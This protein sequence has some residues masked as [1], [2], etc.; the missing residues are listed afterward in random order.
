MK[1]MRRNLLLSIVAALILV[2]LIMTLGPIGTFQIGPSSSSNGSESTSYYEDFDGTRIPLGPGETVHKY[3]LSSQGWVEYTGTSSYLPAAEYG[4]RSD[5]FE[6]K[7]MYYDPTTGTTGT[8]V[9]VPTGQD[10]EAYHVDAEIS[11]LTENRTWYTN[12]DFTGSATGWT[13][14]TAGAGGNSNPISEWMENGTAPG[15]DCIHFEIDSTSSGPTYWYDADDRAYITQTATIPRGDVV[16]AGLRLNYWADTTDDSHYGMTGSFLIYAN[17]EGSRVWTMV[18][19]DI[20]AEETWYDSGI[21]RV[22]NS[23]FNLPTDQS[24]SLEIGLLSTV[25]VGYEPEIGPN[26]RVDDVVLYVKTKATPTNVNLQ[27]NG[28][29]VS[30]GTGWGVGSISETPATPWTKNPVLLNFT[31]TPT[32]ATPD[33]NLTIDVEFDVTTNMFARRT[34]ARTVYDISPTAYG[35]RFTVQN[36]TATNFTTYFNAEIPDGYVNRYFFNLTI[37]SSRDVFFV[38]RPLAPSTNLTSGWT[39]GDTGDGYLNVSAYEVATG[40]GRYGYWRIK[41]QSSN[42]ITDIELLDPATSTWKRFPIIRAGNNTQVRVNVGASFVNSIVNITIFDPSGATW[43]S[44]NATVDGS[45]YATTGVLNFAGSN[46]S[47]GSWMIQATTNDFGTHGTWR[48]TGF[49]KRG[50]SVVHSSEMTIDYPADAVGTWLTNVTYGDFLLVI[51]NVTD[52][53]SSVMLPGGTLE[54]AWALGTGTFDDSGNGQYTKVFDTSTLPGKGQYQLALNWYKDDFD[55][56]TAQLTIN[57]N[58]A[59]KLTSPDYPGIEGPIGLSQSFLVN[60]TNVNGTGISGASISCNWSNPYTVTEQGGGIYKITLDTTSMTIN[61]YPVMVNAS[62]PFVE[63]NSLLMFVEIREIYNTVSYTANQLSIPVGEAAS[64]VITWTDSDTGNPITGGASY[65]TCN[66]TSFHSSGEQNYT[67]T[68]ISPGQ[69]NVTIYTE[70]DDPLTAQGEYYKVQF[71][72]TRKNYQNHTFY[73]DVQIRQHNTLFILDDPVEQTLYGDPITVLVYYEDTDLSEPI[74]NSTG[75]VRIT[76]TSPGVATLVYSTAISNT[77]SGH[78]NITIPSKQWGS[79]GWKNLTIFVEWTGPVNKYQN[80]TI[81]TSVRILGTETDLFLDLAPTATVYLNNFTFT[82]VYY[83]N[84]NGT[85]ISNSTNNVIYE[86]IPLTAGH[87]VTQADFEM[88]ESVTNPGTYQFSLNTS[89]FGLTGTFRFRIN[90]MWSAGVQPFYEN[91]TMTITLV[92]L[93]RSTYIDYSPVQATPYGEIADFTFSYVDSLATKRIENASNLIISLNEGGVS[94][95]IEYNAT[96]RTFTLHIDTS[97][98]GGIGTF[99]LHLN[100]TW[101]GEPYYSSVQ[102]KSFSVTVTE[103]STQLSHESFANPQW[104]NNVTIVFIYTDLLTASSA[105]MTGTLTLDAFLNGW[106]TV[107]YLGDGQYSVEID[108]HGFASDGQYNLNAKIVYSGSNHEADASDLF[109]ITILRRSTQLGYESPDPTPFLENVTFVIIYTDD[110]S[111]AGIDSATIEVSCAT[112]NESLTINVNYWVVPLGSGQYRI[113]VNSTALGSVTSYSLNVTASWT[114]APYYNP[115]SIMVS[116]SVTQRPTLIVI[117]QTPGE[118]PFLENVTFKFRFEDYLTSALISIGKDNIALTHGTGHTPILSNQ[119]A[120]YNHGTYYEISFSSTWISSTSLVTNHGIQITIDKSAGLPFYAMRNSSTTVTTIERPT[121]IQFPSIEDTPYMDNVTMSLEYIDYLSGGGIAGAT[122]TLNIAGFPSVTYYI[123]DL[124]GGQYRVVIPSEQF[125]GAM[126]LSIDITAS[127]SGSPFYATRQATDIPAVIRAIKTSLLSEAPPAGYVPVGD[128]IVVNL[129]FTDFDHSLPIDGAT[130][131]TNWV[132][133]YGTD[134]TFSSLGNGQY[135]LVINSTGLLAQSY[136]FSI[137]AQKSNYETANITLSVQPGSGVVE[138]ILDK[139]TYYADWGDLTTI[140]FSVLETY[141][142]TYVEGMN[143]TL[144]WNGTLYSF[145]D[146][147]NGTYAIV[148]DTSHNNVG[149]FSPQISVSKQYYQTRYKSFTLVVSKATGQIIPESTLFNVVHDTNM[150]FWVYLND[151]NRNLPVLGAQVTLEWNNTPYVMTNNGTPGFYFGNISTI[152]FSSGLY[153]AEVSVFSTNIQFLSAILEIHVIPTPAQ[154]FCRNQ[155]TLY[156]GESLELLVSYNDTYYGGMISGATITYTISNL[157]GSLT[158]LPNGTYY[159]TVSTGSLATGTY[160]LRLTASKSN[161]S[162]YVRNVLVNL[163]PLPTEVL[164]KGVPTL[165]GYPHHNISFILQYNDIRANSSIANAD[166]FVTWSGPS[167]IVTYMGNGRYNITVNL[168]GLLPKLYDVKIQFYKANYLPASKQ[169]QIVV[170]PTPAQI[171]GPSTAS[172]PINDTRSFIFTVYNKLSGE[173]VSDINGMAYWSLGPNPLIPLDNG[174]YSFELPNDLP[175][176]SYEIEIAFST[177][178]YTIAPFKL[179]LNVR[180]IHTSLLYLNNTIFTS[181]GST[182]ELRVT[183]L[184]IDHNLGISGASYSVV[185]SEQNITYY[186]DLTTEANGTYRFV[187]QVISSR[188]LTITI[189]FAKDDYESQV[190]VLTIYS[191]LSSQQILAQQ[192]R[193]YGIVGLFILAG[194]IYA[195]AKYFSVPKLIRVMNSMI[196]A[197]KRGKIPKPY[198][199]RS[200]AEI[201]QEIANEYLAAIGLS[202]PIEDITGETIQVD[203]PEVNKLLDRLAEIT[204]LGPEEIEAFRA[205]LARMKPSERTGFL[206]EVIAQEEARRAEALAEAEAPAPIEEAPEM[207]PEQLDELRLRLEKKGLGEDEIE[208]IIEQAKSLSKADLEALLS[209]LGIKL[210]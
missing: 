128:P 60:F 145:I 161:Y 139:T 74:V 50:F 85:R 87:P 119:Y 26:A 121:Q 179:N 193:T 9:L 109:T 190:L 95:T 181:P 78:Y 166:V 48:A 10:W 71:N 3:V 189:T 114:G 1:R 90:F 105:G 4:N 86:I 112:S 21:I 39:G 111:G 155:Y 106:Y 88:M 134:A 83:D 28:N 75:Y 144:L 92:V 183:Y 203:V 156:Y 133:L 65:I 186:K 79:T 46:S 173:V 136:E 177:S 205:D 169:I 200:R 113:L 45:G 67:V 115:L 61:D 135:Q 175:I 29:A 184:D 84:I 141:M 69:Y 43:K 76:V 56:S 13:L 58:Y 14:G 204:G 100:V 188:T 160:Y 158:E 104:G 70:S 159:A 94:F 68:E 64:F 6:G 7:R 22:Q 38:A 125:G 107:T 140:R 96:E 168:G 24:V 163:L 110:S 196:A 209:S 123:T 101:V 180:S 201:L 172:I 11:G 132:A 53:D 170:R 118:V 108:T 147:G 89:R 174:S 117:T 187:F 131:S 30:S 73:I 210:D 191:D 44:V 137:Q 20:G 18:F 32:P 122:I 17:V 142:N 199:A 185:Y 42:M 182:I 37:P 80:Q 47:A 57:V 8:N 154:I 34:T 164:V 202:K 63:P 72:V 40:A 178:M 151:T 81:N 127:K 195:Y 98:L 129:T 194:L 15:D 143:A 77:G 31:W 208:I 124:T 55:N 82:V 36:A 5:L 171:V 157:T 146:L 97:S 120:L 2:Q 148:L 152:G 149:V 197:L 62:A 176:D 25:T 12:P 23:I 66:W 93:E 51:I 126:T 150:T 102:S 54:Y 165:E 91:Q 49:F 33:P 16:W 59:T 19:S 99:T 130:L 153:L 41:S 35:E 198:A 27:M 167:A 207:L 103:R 206:M 138:I 192:V 162:T 52:L 116:A